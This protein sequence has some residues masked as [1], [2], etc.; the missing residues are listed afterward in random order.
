MGKL[1]F[2]GAATKYSAFLK[3]SRKDKM[4]PMTF[5]NPW[6]PKIRLSKDTLIYMHSH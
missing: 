6:N 2:M 4:N 3:I 1:L 5:V